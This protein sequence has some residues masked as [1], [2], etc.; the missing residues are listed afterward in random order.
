[1]TD[2]PIV[3]EVRRVREALAAKFNYD[4]DAILADIRSRE[5]ASGVKLRYPKDHVASD[6]EKMSTNRL[7]S[8]Q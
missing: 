4:I 1:M 3:A 5:L 7:V 2:D 6:G 8:A